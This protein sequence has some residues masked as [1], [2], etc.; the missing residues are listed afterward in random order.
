MHLSRSLGRTSRVA[1]QAKPLMAATLEVRPLA[2]R[3]GFF[4]VFCFCRMRLQ[5]ASR[6]TTN[7]HGR[8][9]TSA[10]AELAAIARNAAGAALLAGAKA[11]KLDASAVDLLRLVKVRCRRCAPSSVRGCP[12][13]P[14]SSAHG[15]TRVPWSTPHAG[16]L[17]YPW[18]THAAEYLPFLH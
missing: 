17:D 13:A 18:S 3:V 10:C 11:K 14:E 5:S 2:L 6:M 12:S 15:S 8:A 1:S 16:V 9:E 4:G 7:L